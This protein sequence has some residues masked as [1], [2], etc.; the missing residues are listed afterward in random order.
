MNQIYLKN[1]MLTMPAW[2]CH[3]CAAFP[4]RNRIIFDA[5]F[6]DIYSLCVPH[7][8]LIARH[9]VPYFLKIKEKMLIMFIKSRINKFSLS[10]GEWF[11]HTELV[12]QWVDFLFKKTNSVKWVLIVRLWVSRKM[13]TN[14]FS[15][16]H[17][18]L[19]Q[20]QSVRSVQFSYLWIL[21]WEVLP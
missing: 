18:I 3:L 4:C 9:T 12:K 8:Y 19:N 2:I 10:R 5:G 11:I 20:S 13:Q 1:C 7:S 15:M 6:R 17:L 14:R 16:A 21:T